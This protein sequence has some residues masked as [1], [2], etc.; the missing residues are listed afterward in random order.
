MK[1]SMLVLG[2]VFASVVA[3]A[4]FGQTYPS[5]PVRLIVPFAP[6]GGTD[7]LARVIAQRVSE[8]L[9]QSVV[10]DNRGGGGGSIGTEMAVRAS[11]D[12]YTLIFVS[13]SYAAAAAL[14]K[15]PYDPVADIQPISMVGET[16][17]LMAVH[18]SMPVKS[19]KELIA[20]AKANPGKVNFGS[21][22]TGSVMHLSME[23]FKLETKTDL[24][25]IPYKGG[26]PALNAI[27]GG[28]IQ[29]TAISILATIPH[30]KS[31]RLRAIGVTTTKRSAAIP[32]VATIGETVPGY[33]VFHWYGV[34][35]PKGLPKEVVVLWN[36]EIGK[37][38]QTED[39]KARMAG[40]GL[41][42]VSGL[43]EHFR[44]VIKRDV[45]KWRR[46]VKEVGISASD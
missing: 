23:L 22:G 1:L 10:V 28:Q 5:R 30:V 37:V 26:G 3:T 31:G 39:M 6:G 36:R 9:G 43:P 16:G 15:L 13:G 14:Y 19:T 32:D 18:P 35:G 42:A 41:E 8:S 46:V 29:L 34:W 4:T 11:P 45:E 24:N 40:E 20:Y 38:L 27:I 12:G 33:E 25:H 21:V 2:A 44:N 17:F 7:I